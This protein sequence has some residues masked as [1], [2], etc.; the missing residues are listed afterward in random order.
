MN[1]TFT[2]EIERASLDHVLS[3]ARM[4]LGIAWK[5]AISALAVAIVLGMV[6]GRSA[7]S[8]K[9]SLDDPAPVVVKGEG[10]HYRIFTQIPSDKELLHVELIDPVGKRHLNLTYHRKGLSH[11]FTSRAERFQLGYLART[12][13]EEIA[14]VRTPLAHYSVDLLTGGESGVVVN[15]PGYQQ[16]LGEIWITPEG[17]R[18]PPRDPG[19]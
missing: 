1:R 6:A 5:L 17:K 16:R 9:P 2:S 13:G 19:E 11:F 12:G 8:E 15:S 4:T 14:S 10:N 18:R 3:A 7:R